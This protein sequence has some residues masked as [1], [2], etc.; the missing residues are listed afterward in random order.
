MTNYPLKLI[1]CSTHWEV[2][3]VFYSRSVAYKDEIYS[4]ALYS[5]VLFHSRPGESKIRGKG[6]MNRKV[7]TLVHKD[8]KVIQYIQL[9]CPID[10]ILKK[11]ATHSHYIL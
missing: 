6:L 2:S 4:H 3:V 8:D 7:I 11:V 1:K 9:L 5:K 10:F